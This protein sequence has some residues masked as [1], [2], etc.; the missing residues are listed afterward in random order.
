[1]KFHRCRRASFRGLFPASIRYGSAVKRSFMLIDGYGSSNWRAHSAISRV[2][3]YASKGTRSITRVI[4]MPRNAA[5]EKV[6]LYFSP[7]SPLRSNVFEYANAAPSGADSNVKCATKN[8]RST[9]AR[10]EK[11]RQVRQ[12]N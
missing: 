4:E 12:C 7:Q 2:T 5:T 1:M 11:R 8:P 3:P 6:R 10:E 9:T